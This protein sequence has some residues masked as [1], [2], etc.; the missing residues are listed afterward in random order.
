M[1]FS[2]L[3]TKIFI[4]VLTLPGFTELEIYLVVLG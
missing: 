1:F 3:P 2:M 4:L